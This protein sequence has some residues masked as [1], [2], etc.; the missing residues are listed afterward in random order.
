VPENTTKLG[1][2]P[3]NGHGNRLPDTRSKRDQVAPVTIQIF[4]TWHTS[5]IYLALWIT[6]IDFPDSF[7]N[8]VFQIFLA[9]STHVQI[10]GL[11][12]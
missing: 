2:T 3:T 12:E 11:G 6:F 4:R 8:S 5:R 9:K 1:G 7:S 10:E